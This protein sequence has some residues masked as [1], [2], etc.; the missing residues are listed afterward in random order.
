MSKLKKWHQKGKKCYTNAKLILKDV[1]NTV[2]TSTN[3]EILHDAFITQANKKLATINDC[4]TYYRNNTH[5][6]DKKVLE[7]AR[8]LIMDT[9]SIK[10]TDQFFDYVFDHRDDFTEMG[11]DTYNVIQFF[12]NQ[13]NYFDD[14]IKTYKIFE[15][16]KNFITDDQ[17]ISIAERIHEILNMDAPYND[18]KEL[19][20]LCDD[21]LEKHED[22][23]STE[24]LTPQNDI[25]LESDEVMDVLNEDYEY[26]EELIAEY[27]TTFTKD[28]DKLNKK[29]NKATEISVIKGVSDEAFNL[30]IKCLDKINKFKKSMNP[31]PK[32]PEPEIKSVDLSVKFIA[33]KSNIKIETDEELDMFLN[34]IRTEV[35]KRLEENDVVNLKL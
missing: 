19:P 20:Q 15:S 25:K 28:F 13:K 12:N 24:K 2:E 16:N 22:I 18:I 31:E 5:Y 21:F 23:I 34:K 35:K 9:I 17:L 11:E 3:D 32:D 4:L 6:P 10:S 26:K 14:A 8:D 29:L 7:N 1:F 30:K 27:E 33:S